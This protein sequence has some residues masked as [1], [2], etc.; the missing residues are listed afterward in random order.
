[1]KL[2]RY[3]V[4]LGLIAFLLTQVNLGDTLSALQSLN[5]PA[6]LL[7]VSAIVLHRL[8]TIKKWTMLLHAK[9]YN[10]PFLGMGQ[11]WLINNFSGQ[12][13]PATVGEDIAKSL[14]LGRYISN[15]PD[16]ASSV[17]TDRI[18]GIVSLLLTAAGAG[19]FAFRFGASDQ[20]MFIPILGS[21]AVVL[22]LLTYNYKRIWHFVKK[23][24]GLGHG[25]SARIVDKLSEITESVCQYRKHEG[26]LFAAFL[27]SLLAQCLRVIVVLFAGFAIGL[28]APIQYYFIFVPIILVAT[29]LPFT[30]GGIG[31]RETTFVY[32]FALVSVP[33]SA[34]LALAILTYLLELAASIPG[35]LLY[36]YAGLPDPL[37]ERTRIVD[38][39]Q[40]ALLAKP[41]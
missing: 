10:V 22:A 34:A 1:M 15:L 26:T 28:N 2:L 5:T 13:L 39:T 23:K 36:A 18:I 38:P 32:F 33:P 27:M 35:G 20:I 12:F 19:F 29:L 41:K 25:V 17:I 14:S 21:A 6:V 7:A 8:T 30:V 3:I 9:G 37:E 11:I 24:T 40:T 4:S 16:A 31:I